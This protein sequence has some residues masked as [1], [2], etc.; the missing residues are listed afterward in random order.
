MCIRDRDVAILTL[1]TAQK[2]IVELVVTDISGK[3]LS[4]QRVSVIA[5]DNQLPLKVAALPSGTYSV[6]AITEDGGTKTL[7]FMKQ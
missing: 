5:G 1:T 6:T 7:R 4:K 2:G 3:Q